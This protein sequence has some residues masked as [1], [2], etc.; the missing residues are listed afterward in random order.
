MTLSYPCGPGTGKLVQIK[1]ST[2]GLSLKIVLISLGGADVETLTTE[3]RIT[4]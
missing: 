3:I 2:S 4:T 1:A